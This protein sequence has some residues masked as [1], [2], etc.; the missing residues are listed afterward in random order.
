MVCFIC[1]KI[2]QNQDKTQNQV[3]SLLGFQ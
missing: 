3:W 1:T 2:I